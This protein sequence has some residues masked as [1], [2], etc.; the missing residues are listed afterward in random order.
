V[1]NREDVLPRHAHERRPQ[2]FAPSTDWRTVSAALRQQVAQPTADQKELAD[3][4]G[5]QLPADLPA[6]VAAALLRERLAGPLALRSYDYVSEGSVK[7]VES[8]STETGLRP[9]TKLSSPDV[10]DAWVEVLHAVRATEALERLQPAVGDVVVVDYNGREWLAEIGSISSDGQLNFRG[11][12]GWR[13]RPHLVHVQARVD[14]PGSAQIR[15]KAQQMAALRRQPG[16]TIGMRR[17]QL[18]EE[19]KV[20]GDPTRA[21]VAALERAVNHATDEKPIQAVLQ[22]NPQL[23]A[24]LF[25]AHHGAYLVP[26]L[27]FGDK[28]VA[29]FVVGGLTSAGLS[30]TFVELESPTAPL[31]IKDGQPA[32]QLRKGLQQITDWREWVGNNLQTARNERALGGLGLFEVRPRARGLVIVGRR[33]LTHQAETIRN[34]IWEDRHIDIRTYDWLV[35]AARFKRRFSWGVL[36]AELEFAGEFDGW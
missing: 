1:I 25:D 36:D 12:G 35:A 4:V 28:Y 29:D 8:L 18:L 9:S 10:V 33:S 27:R 30:W 3:Q 13:A 32:G 17:L 5:L 21:Q 26:Q 16:D 20:E 7:Y 34:V 2:T 22:E 11:G 24:Y 23:L 14:A 15:H 19:W 6:P 31:S